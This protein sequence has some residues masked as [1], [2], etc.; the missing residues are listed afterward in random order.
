MVQTL[1]YEQITTN[2][3][4]VDEWICDPALMKCLVTLTLDT[5]LC[6]G[7]AR[8]SLVGTTSDGSLNKRGLYRIMYRCC[9]RSVTGTGLTLS[10]VALLHYIRQKMLYIFAA[11]GSSFSLPSPLLTTFQQASR[12]YKLTNKEGWYHVLGWSS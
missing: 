12:V 7:D 5:G 9:T 8:I 2:M 3:V 11:C 10:A 6:V 1:Y 4:S